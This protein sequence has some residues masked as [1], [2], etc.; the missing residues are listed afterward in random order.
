MKIDESRY[1]DKELYYD[2]ETNM[3][4]MRCFKAIVSDLMET[5][6]IQTCGICF[7]SIRHYSLVTQKLGRDSANAIISQFI[8]QLQDKLSK[9]GIICHVGGDNFITVFDKLKLYDLVDHLQGIGV[10][11]DFEKGKQILISACAGCYM[12][13]GENDVDSL[14]NKAHLAAQEARRRESNNC[15]FYDKKLQ[16][17]SDHTYLIESL[18]ES[19][20]EKEEFKVYY[21]P[22]IRLTDYRL[23]GAEALCRWNHDGQIVPPGEFIPALEQSSAICDLD[24]YMLEHVCQ[25]IRRW[26]DA[27]ESVVRVSVNLSRRHMGDP[28]LLKHIIDIV[29]RYQVPH[30]YIEI[31]LTETTTDISFKDLKQIVVGLKEQ[32]IVTSVDDFGEGYSSMNLIRQLPWGAIKLDRSFLP[33]HDRD[34]SPEKIMLYHLLQMIHDMGILCFVE[35]VENIEQVKLLKEYGCRYVQGFYFDRPLPVEEFEKRLKELKEN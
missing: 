29:D 20:L 31:E 32:G 12:V 6:Q 17:T 2:A 14:I 24:F 3:S 34:E 5:N 13:E 28:D 15:V 23:E 30:E 10:T 25:D 19:A 18:F 35:G 11:Y 4:N 7:F 27:G 1:S 9:D 21:Q 16:K 33:N 8:K 26:I 22:K